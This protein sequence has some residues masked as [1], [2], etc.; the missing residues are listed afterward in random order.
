M[1]PDWL[2]QLITISSD[3][4]NNFVQTQIKQEYEWPQNENQPKLKGRPGRK[5]K[6]SDSELTPIE[7]E[8]RELRRLRNKQAA[9]RCRQRRLEKTFTLEQ[10]VT[11]F[12][13]SFFSITKIT[14]IKGGYYF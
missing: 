12:Y 4:F 13:R 11:S 2:N 8:K 3:A 5:A 9:R 10:K 1:K 14:E 6:L 7:L